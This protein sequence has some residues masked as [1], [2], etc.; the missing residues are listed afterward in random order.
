ML[1]FGPFTCDEVLGMRRV[2][3]LL[4]VFALATSCGGGDGTERTR[5]ELPFLTFSVKSL[6]FGP[7]SHADAS[8]PYSIVLKG[9]EREAACQSPN[10]LPSGSK[11]VW[12]TL[13]PG[14]R[15]W[16]DPPF[17]CALGKGLPNC[18]A[19]VS[20]FRQDGGTR[21]Q[22]SGV[23]G[24]VIVH[25]LKDD[26]VSTELQ[27]DVARSPRVCEG[28]HCTCKDDVCPETAPTDRLSLI[29][30]AEL[31]PAACVCDD[32]GAKDAC[33]CDG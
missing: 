31:C 13:F 25:E 15:G 24:V 19:E 29:L 4:G 22:W 26:R 12:V 27:V 17:V 30:D 6:F 32:A 8:D 21:T 20:V 18:G 3:L 33:V 11:E 9:T 10:D 1:G 7:R 5:L 16:P 14:E 23:S 2:L 28:S